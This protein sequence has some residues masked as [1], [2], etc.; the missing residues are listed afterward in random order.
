MFLTFDYME[1]IMSK[2][3]I[4]MDNAATTKVAPQVLDAMMPYFSEIYAN[5]SSSDRQPRKL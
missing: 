1:D 4:Y 2:P 5:G 3:F